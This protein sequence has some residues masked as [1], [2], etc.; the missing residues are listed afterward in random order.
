MYP[1]QVLIRKTGGTLILDGATF[2]KSNSRNQFINAPSSAQDIS[3]Y[4]GGVNC[5]GSV[6]DLLSAKARKDSVKVTTAGVATA[7]TLNDGGGAEVFSE[8]DVVTYNTTILMAGRIAALINASGTCDITAT[9][10]GDGTFNLIADVAGTNY[11]QASLTNVTNTQLV[12]NSFL[13]TET[14]GGSL[15]ESPNV[16]Y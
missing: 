15:I 8:A 7:I 9:D 11:T 14:V 16:V 13:I 3:V 12:L 6:G 1:Y 10:N 4:S 5:N 2:V